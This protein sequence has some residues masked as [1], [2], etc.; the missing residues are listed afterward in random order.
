MCARCATRWGLPVGDHRPC[1][2]RRGHRVVA[3]GRRRSSRAI[4]ARALDE[5]RRSSTSAIARR[6]PAGARRPRP[7]APE[8]PVDTPAGAGH[9]SGRRAA[10]PPRVAEPAARAPR[11]R[12]VRP[13]RPGEHGRRSGSWRGGHAHQ[14]HD[15]GA[16][17]DD[18]RQRGRSA[19]SIRGSAPRCRRRGGPQRRDH[20]RPAAGRHELPQL[21]GPDAARG[22]LAAPGGGSAASAT[23]AVRSAC[24]SP[25]ATSRSTTRR[26]AGAIAP[27]ARDRRR[28][29][30]GGRREARG[31]RVHR[32]TATRRARRGGDVPGLA[33]S[34]YARIAGTAAEDHPPAIDLA[35][36]AAVQRF[37][38][39]AIGRGSSSRP[40]TSRGGGLAV[41]LA[42]SAIWGGRRRIA[43]GAR[44]RLARGRAVRRR[45]VAAR[46][47]S[48]SRG[49][50]RR[51]ILLAREYGLPGR[52]ARHD[53]RRPP[54]DR[55]RRARARPVPPR[56]AAA[57]SPMRWTCASPT[58]A[59]RG[60]TA[61]RAPSAGMRRRGRA[62]MCGVSGVV[63]PTARGS[64]LPR[65]RR[66]ACSRCSTEARN[67]PAWPSATASS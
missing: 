45:P 4:P 17:R 51:C 64:R 33:G 29:A 53:R 27:D 57:A 48:A 46:R 22:V 10:G 67:R 26:P 32:A 52:G 5:R 6:P 7:G 3:G 35:R 58:C 63:L 21:R 39:E 60:T 1:H 54:V 14:G 20:R 24:R 56:S 62:L 65:W 59:T 41:A 34:E 40:R 8:E 30:A 25:A 13:Q 31:S 36:E 49:T 23:R 42:E 15:E 38:R 2:R 66:S 61:S 9:G 37:I 44:R 12:A 43:A 55:A 18:G 50:S 47:A 11:L 16:G 19:R 28:R